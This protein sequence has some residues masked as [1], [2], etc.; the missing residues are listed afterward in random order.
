MTSNIRRIRRA[1]Y[2]THLDVRDHGIYDHRSLLAQ[3]PNVVL[4]GARR[5]LPVAEKKLIAVMRAYSAWRTQ[6]A[7]MRALLGWL[8]HH[9][10]LE[11]TRLLR[12]LWLVDEAQRLELASRQKRTDWARWDCWD[13]DLALTWAMAAAARRHASVA[14]VIV[15]TD[16][17]L[18]KLH[19]VHEEFLRNAPPASRSRSQPRFPKGQPS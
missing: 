19:D 11:V 8:E 14:R 13:D 2:I 9:P 15:E 4:G 12:V 16:C 7:K 5:H 10:H 18:K 1:A 6:P 3:S 17:K